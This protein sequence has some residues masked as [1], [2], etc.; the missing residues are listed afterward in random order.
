MYI[1]IYIII[2]ILNDDDDNYENILKFKLNCISYITMMI[3]VRY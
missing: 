2:K 3:I 1:Y